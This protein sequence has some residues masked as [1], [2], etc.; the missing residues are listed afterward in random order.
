M[1]RRLVLIAALLFAFPLAVSRP[2]LAVLPSEMLK[3]P[4][5][6]ARAREISKGLRCLVCR[7]ENIDDSNAKLAHD[8]RVLVRDRLKAGDTDQQVVDYIVARY[9]EY[10]L[11]RPRVT[12]ANL[13]LWAAGPIM[14]LLAGWIG[15]RYVRSQR[16][17]GQGDGQGDGLSDEEQ[18]RLRELMSD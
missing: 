17:D 16:G 3:D 5:L 1:I 8:L 12:G 15:Y 18:A 10:V 4:V 14:L 6:E 2:A 11:L 7:N 13:L 9:G